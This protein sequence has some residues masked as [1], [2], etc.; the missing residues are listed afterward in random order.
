MPE[1]TEEKKDK[2]PRMIAGGLCVTAGV[3]LGMGA[4]FALHN[5]PAGLFIGLGAG[6]LAFA[7]IMIIKRR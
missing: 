4:G 5:V 2:D 7:L 3:L 6:F 1:A